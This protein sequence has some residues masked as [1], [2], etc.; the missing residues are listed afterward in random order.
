MVRRYGRL[1]V[2]AGHHAGRAIDLALDENS[3]N[4]FVISRAVNWWLHVGMVRPRLLWGEQA[5]GIVFGSNSLFGHLALQL[6]LAIGKTEGLAVCSNC[7]RIYAPSRQ[8]TAGKRSYC[9]TC[10][11]KGVAV[12]DAQ[13]DHRYRRRK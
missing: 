6:L 7:E 13:R 1:S 2:V 4:H 9:S 5:A 10:R 3:A 12:R 11:E 8:P